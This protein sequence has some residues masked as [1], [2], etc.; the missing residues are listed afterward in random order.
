[1]PTLTSSYGVNYNVRHVQLHDQLISLQRILFSQQDAHTLLTQF[2][3]YTEREK[4]KETTKS[5]IIMAHEPSSETRVVVISGSYGT[6]MAW[7]P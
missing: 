5:A 1:M 7:S 6:E 3:H 4:E 2:K